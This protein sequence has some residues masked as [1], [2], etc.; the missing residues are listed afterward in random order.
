[1]NAAQLKRLRNGLPDGCPLHS[2]W[3]AVQHGERLV[4]GVFFVSTAGH[5]GIKL[6]QARNALIPDVF[7]REGGWYEEDCDW[8]IPMYFLELK[9]EKKEVRSRPCATGT[10]GLR[11]LVQG[12]HPA[13]QQLSQGRAFE[14]EDIERSL[15]AVKR[16]AF[17]STS[18]ASVNL[19]RART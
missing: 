18:T 2:P 12:D 5:G 6:S 7:R 4:D 13:R 15:C 3:G 8:A 11:V 16:L 9:P 1:M 19:L 17:E 10:G 14:L